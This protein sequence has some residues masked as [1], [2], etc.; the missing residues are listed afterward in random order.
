[1]NWWTTLHEGKMVLHSEIRVDP[2]TNKVARRDQVYDST[3][4][5]IHPTEVSFNIPNLWHKQIT[6]AGGVP[7]IDNKIILMAK[8]IGMFGDVEGFRVTVAR[9]GLKATDWV[10]ENCYLGKFNDTVKLCKNRMHIQSVAKR[11]ASS[12]FTDELL[13]AFD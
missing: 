10:K 12:Q 1:M 8:P 9:K 4:D 6:A 2:N 3:G 11:K 5:Y 7:C 13:S